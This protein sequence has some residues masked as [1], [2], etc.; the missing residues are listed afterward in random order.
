MKKR[1]AFYC[2]AV[3]FALTYSWLAVANIQK[4]PN[5]HREYRAFELENQMKVMVISDREAQRAAASLSVLV[6]GGSD[7]E[8]RN[9]MAHFLEHMLFLGTEKYPQLDGYRAFIEQNG[10]SSNAYTAI[11]LTNYQFTIEPDFLHPALDRFAQFF[12]TPLFPVEQVNR[13]RAVVHAEFEM[14][15]QRD[16]IR[17]WS[18]MRQAYNSQHP[19]S[20][21]VS[22]NEDTL[23]G[24]VRPELIEFFEKHYS[25][26]LM[27]LVVIGR[28]SPDQLQSWV[29]GIFSD[30]ANTHAQPLQVDA[31][32]FS[33]DSLPALL[34]YKTLKD[35]PK[36]TFMFPV[37]NLRPYWRES[38]SNYI[39]NLLGHEGKGSLLSQLKRRGW[40][41]GLYAGS[42]NTG[43]NSHTV[44]VVISLTPSGLQNWQ[45]IGAYVFQY[46]RELRQRG[47]EQWRFKEQKLLADLNY[48][49]AEID[50]SSSYATVLADALHF[51]PSNDILKALY[52]V[53][54]FD[55]QLIDDILAR[56]NP[57]NVLTILTAPTVLTDRKTPFIGSE[58]SIQ[59]VSSQTVSLWQSDI[60]NASGWLPQPNDFLPNNF[61]MVTAD[62]QVK[63]KP[64]SQSQ[65][66]Q[67]WYDKDVSFDVP[68]ANFY[69]S[70][71]SP[72]KQM[73]VKNSVLLDLFVETVN[74]QLNEYSYPAALAGLSYS[75]Y[76]HS[77]GL[78][79]KI[80]GYNDKQSVLL[81]TIIDALK[82]PE[83]DAKQF[84]THRSQFIR[85]VKN[86]SKD[87]A[88][89][90]GFA[91]FYAI[92]LDPSWN[93][94]QKIKA[95][96]QVS[97]ADLKEFADKYFNEVNVVALSHG[98]IS[99]Q[100][101][102]EM[103]K[104]ISDKLLTSASF[105]DVA[106]SRVLE[107]PETGPFVRAQAIENGDSAISVYIQGADRSL[108]ERARFGMLA[109]T[110]QTE[111][112]SELRSV[113]QLGYVVFSS[114]TPLDQ[115]PGISFVVQSPQVKPVDMEIA[116]DKF[117]DQFHGWLIEMPQDEF[118]KHREGLIAR[119]L[120]K[121]STLT[122]RSDRYWVAIDDKDFEFNL[123]EQVAAQ[124][125]S[126]DRTAFE[127]FVS[128]LLNNKRDSRLVILSYGDKFSV[129]DHFDNGIGVG[130][131]DINEFKRQHK[132]FPSV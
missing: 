40:A 23:A 3:V 68:R 83:F 62:S 105:V 45:D 96:E 42:G 54:K 19:S 20:K 50:S 120:R 85:D 124:I 8:G 36:L 24:D 12:I 31:P 125:R 79:M 95:A 103:G 38:P 11:D 76:S 69:V 53:E 29:E 66:F 132:F 93:D 109:Q 112:F 57:E 121:E 27:T 17:R 48:R 107:L 9:G 70:V 104:M 47:I 128:D 41:E 37:Q 21:F 88:Y 71:R 4:S 58:Y 106:K 32:L 110:L 14:R 101:A 7:P 73:N 63:P 43:L 98:N 99:E 89:H 108:A 64:V 129:P 65:G 94:A 44:S 35:E 74:E 100:D 131:S 92:M 46:I 116:I 15:K 75:L 80:S 127:D 122:E 81:A 61:E 6:G 117:L 126:V 2:I 130:I 102:A 55:P 97:L 82:S 91:Q 90:R 26:N 77:R 78:T 34:Q 87:E 52:L 33:D 51:Y 10:G 123:S 30:V 16:S 22:G 60:A 84:E 67:L 25:A 1:I 114:Y 111:F 49:F 5:D 18:A 113:Q 115:I 13:E 39:G 72:L 118:E 59:P 86:R 119:V 56:M 28:E